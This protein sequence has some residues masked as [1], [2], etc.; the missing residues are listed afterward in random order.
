MNANRRPRE[1]LLDDVLSHKSILATEFASDS[2]KSEGT[3]C[4]PF[5]W[6][7]LISEA[8]EE[9]AREEE[10]AVCTS[11]P[12]PPQPLA[13]TLRIRARHAHYKLC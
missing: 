1:R 2:I 7:V 11:A 9:V 3:S 10:A 5:S 12:A 13:N 8:L 6:Q 4:L